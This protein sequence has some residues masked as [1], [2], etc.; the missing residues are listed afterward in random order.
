M[1]DRTL[2]ILTLT[3]LTPLLVSADEPDAFALAGTQWAQVIIHERMVIRIPRTDSNDN[4]RPLYRAPPSENGWSEQKA[5]KCVPSDS[6]VAAAMDGGD[7]DLSM[8]DGARLRAKL[9]DNCPTLKFYT[10]FYLKRTADGLICAGRD[11]LRS[12]SG[13]RCDIVRFRT[14]VARR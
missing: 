12:R 8:V 5:P 6:I 14:L 3:A 11:A 4:A 7:V 13:A 1:F 9:G 10:G 2:P